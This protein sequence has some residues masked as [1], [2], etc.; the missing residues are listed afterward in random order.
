MAAVGQT[1]NAQSKQLVD[2]LNKKHPGTVFIMPTSDAMVLA[3]EY[4][5][6]GKLPGVQGLQNVGGKDRRSGEIV[7]ATSARA[8]TGWK[9]MCFTPRLWPLAR[10]DRW[11]HRF[12]AKIS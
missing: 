11:R 12:A 10:F 4:Y 2:L 8:L 7:L 5:L 3:A 9:V 1:K 6:R